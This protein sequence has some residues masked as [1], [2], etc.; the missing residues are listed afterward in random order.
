MAT[1]KPIP[2]TEATLTLDLLAEAEDVRAAK[3][4]QD[5]PDGDIT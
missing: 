4:D 3:F 2:T 1:N 5:A